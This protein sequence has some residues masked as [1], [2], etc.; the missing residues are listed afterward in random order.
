MGGGGLT[1]G[2]AM[3]RTLRKE[4]L[5]LEAEKQPCEEAAKCIQGT[6]KVQQMRG[7]VSILPSCRSLGGLVKQELPTCE[8]CVAFGNGTEAHRQMS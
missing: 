4:P 8:K 5:N 7:H 6:G 1:F 2:R 3:G